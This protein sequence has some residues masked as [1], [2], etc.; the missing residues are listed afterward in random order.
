M[1]QFFE[2]PDTFIRAWR[3]TIPQVIERRREIASTCLRL[4]WQETPG[5]A[6]CAV[7]PSGVMVVNPGL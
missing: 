5:G 3:K 6:C 7:E 1:H 2:E 4:P